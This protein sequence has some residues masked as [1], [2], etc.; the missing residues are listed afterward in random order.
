MKQFGCDLVVLWQI[1]KVE[2]KKQCGFTKWSKSGVVQ[3]GGS[4]LIST[5]GDMVRLFRVREGCCS[6]VS[7]LDADMVF[8]VEITVWNCARNETVGF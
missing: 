4:D 1:E 2:L 8:Y 3:K 5:P 7:F 6:T